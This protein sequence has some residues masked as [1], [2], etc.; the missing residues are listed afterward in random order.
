MGKAS[1][2][3]EAFCLLL[4]L[5][6]E[7]GLAS[8]DTPDGYCDSSFSTSLKILTPPFAVMLQRMGH[9]GVVTGAVVHSSG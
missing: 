3:A 7:G 4:R 8:L 5:G 2:G 6:S 1:A 9:Y